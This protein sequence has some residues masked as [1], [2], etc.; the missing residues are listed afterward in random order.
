M[1]LATPDWS[2]V[3][4]LGDALL[5]VDVLEHLGGQLESAR[6]LLSIVLQQAT[7]I[8]LGSIPEVVRLAGVLQA[9][10]HRRSLIEVERGGLLEHAARTLGVKP[11]EVS[12]AM[13]EQ[14]VDD[15]WRAVTRG[16]ADELRGLLAEVQREHDGDRLLIQHELALHRS[17]GRPEEAGY[18]AALQSI[19]DVVPISL[20]MQAF[21]Q[22]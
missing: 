12:L 11:T 22:R 19:A 17:R 18:Q 2:S 15:Q 14:V 8:R 16:R 13:L 1:S 10:M 7:A 5:T 21:L 20:E 3:G 9:E 4:I 6:R